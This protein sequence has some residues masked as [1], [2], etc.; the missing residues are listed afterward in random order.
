MKK[1]V[2]LKM[3]WVCMGSSGDGADFFS[4]SVCC[5]VEVPVGLCFKDTAAA[6][7]CYRILL[8]RR[9]GY[10]LHIITLAF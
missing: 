2:A 7:I 8:K 5:I 9:V 1:S 6:L 4:R 3:L 10:I